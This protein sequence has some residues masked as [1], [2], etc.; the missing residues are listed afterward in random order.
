MSI[1]PP[2]T[3]RDTDR[4]RI[5]H[6]PLPRLQLEHTP[7]WRFDVQTERD[8][9]DT[10]L[11]V[12]DSDNRE[13]NLGFGLDVFADGSMSNTLSPSSTTE[14]RDLTPDQLNDLA[15]RTDR[16]QAWL[17][18]LAVVVAWATEHRLELAR[19]ITC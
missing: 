18:D 5:R 9:R 7:G 19:S 12:F 6:P 8:P 16:L 14:T 1:T 10:D 15:D 17:D 4:P 3:I 2:E 11:I 13:F